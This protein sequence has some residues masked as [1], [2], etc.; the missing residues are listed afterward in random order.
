MFFLLFWLMIK[1]S[2]S[3]SVSL[4]N[5][6]GSG[7]PKNIRIRDTALVRGVRFPLFLN[8]SLLS[9][10]EVLESAWTMYCRGRFPA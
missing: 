5:G 7:R 2:R 8:V 4:T 10:S 1:G 6:S 3:G 9:E